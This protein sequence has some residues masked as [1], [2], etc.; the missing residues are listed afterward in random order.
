MQD[1]TGDRGVLKE[2]IRD[3][4]GENVPPDASV[5]GKRRSRRGHLT[6]VGP[7]W[8]TPIICKFLRRRLLLAILR[9]T[10][11]EVEPNML[12]FKKNQTHN[13]GLHWQVWKMSLSD[14]WIN[15]FG[16]GTQNVW[17]DWPACSLVEIVVSICWANVSCQILGCCG[18]SVFSY[19]NV[20][21]F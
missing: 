18:P 2:V 5:L 1:V 7:H 19:L 17:S 3:G 4:S 10:S 8:K 12:A 11:L 21:G 15:C 13:F 16:Q 6:R 20:N 14:I 9:V